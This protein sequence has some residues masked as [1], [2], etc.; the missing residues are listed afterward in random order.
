MMRG[1]VGMVGQ[2]SYLCI[3]LKSFYASVECV[4]RGLDPLRARLVV[5][6]PA[7]TDRTIC[8][9]VSPALKALGVRNRC[10]VFEIPRGIDYVMAVPRMHKYIEYSA[11]I[12]AIYLKY[13]DRQDIHVYSVDEAFMDVTSYLSLYGL[14]APQ[15]ATMIMDDILRTTGIT[16]TA[17]VGTNLYLAK[18]A[19]DII[20]KHAPDHIGV[21]DETDY[22]RRL[23]DH[24]PLTDFWRVGPG[25]ARRLAALGITTMGQLAQAEPEDVIRA[26]GVDGQLL[27]DH[28]WGREPTTIADIKAYRSRSHSL[29][30]GQAIGTACGW[31]RGLLLTKEM[32]EQLCLDMTARRLVTDSLALYVGYAGAPGDGATDRLTVRTNA[33]QVLMDGFTGLYRRLAAHRTDISRIMLS[34]GGVEPMEKES[35]DLFTDTASV[36]RD[37]RVQQALVAIRRRYGV[38]AVVRA[39]DLAPGANAIERNLQIGGHKSGQQS[40]DIR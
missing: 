1:A 11:D 40:K 19:L 26:F 30:N 35:Y 23:W 32:A 24:Q 29:S 14:T 25:I 20:A 21:L 3:D 34:C 17:G 12:Y 33:R 2:R 15:M 31:D 10:R 27:Y 4:E 9:A 39:M 28:A 7:R 8:L 6:D 16:A 5:A 18:I 38:N 36:V 13:V 37:Q 22:R